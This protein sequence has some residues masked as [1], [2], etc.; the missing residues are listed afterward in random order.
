MKFRLNNKLC[1]SLYA[2]VVCL[3]LTSC[4]GY[5]DKDGKIVKDAEGKYY[6]LDHRTG[7]VYALEEINKAEL[8]SLCVR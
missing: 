1:Y 8:D 4:S 3:F 2:V 5:G 7:V 6:R